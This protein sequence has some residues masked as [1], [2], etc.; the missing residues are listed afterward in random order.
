MIAT[1]ITLILV[2]YILLAIIFFVDLTDTSKTIKTKKLFLYWIIPLGMYMLI[3]QWLITL[4]AK[5]Q[6]YYNKLK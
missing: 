6:K 3:L 4:P 5:A 1:L 2:Q